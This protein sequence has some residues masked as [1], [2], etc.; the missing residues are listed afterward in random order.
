MN[1]R[2]TASVLLCVPGLTIEL[3]AGSPIATRHDIHFTMCALAVTMH[4]QDVSWL[5]TDRTSCF[6][7]TIFGVPVSFFLLRFIYYLPPDW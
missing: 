2:A 1:I 5:P 6:Y 4:P 3:I 7:T